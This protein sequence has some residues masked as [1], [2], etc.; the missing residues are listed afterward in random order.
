MPSDSEEASKMLMMNV[1]KNAD[2][3]TESI[4]YVKY[5][6]HMVHVIKLQ[7]IIN[8]IKTL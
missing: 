2:K 1:G 7:F 4:S 5:S 8:L 6:K 3:Y